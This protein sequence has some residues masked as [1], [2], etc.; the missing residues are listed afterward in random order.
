MGKIIINN[1]NH[2]PGKP[3]GSNKEYIAMRNGYIM[4]AYY[5]GMRRKTIADMMGLSHQLVCKVVKE[6]KDA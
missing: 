6:N 1:N 3:L 5:S 4:K 2:T